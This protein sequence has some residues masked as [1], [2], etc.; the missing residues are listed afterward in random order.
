MH[1]YNKLIWTVC[2]YVN[3]VTVLKQVNMIWKYKYQSI[4]CILIY[5]SLQLK[6]TAARN[7]GRGQRF[8]ATGL[9]KIT[10][11]AELCFIHG[12]MLQ[13]NEWVSFIV[14][15]KA[16]TSLGPRVVCLLVLAMSLWEDSF[17]ASIERL[18]L[19]SN[20]EVSLAKIE[21]SLNWMD[22]SNTI[23]LSSRFADGWGVWQKMYWSV[24]V[25]WNW[26]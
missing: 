12:T 9:G 6:A 5:C 19:L 13:L 17:L 10:S 26:F 1:L 3:A 7:D 8:A 21:L 11:S 14:Q 16:D 2:S 25:K 24:T 18:W 22:Q 23:M 15:T 4:K 20:Q